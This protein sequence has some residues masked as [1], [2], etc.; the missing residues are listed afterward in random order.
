V[1]PAF[2][3][4]AATEEDRQKI[5]QELKE[6]NDMILSIKG[7]KIETQVV[8]YYA[9]HKAN[10]AEFDKEG[11]LPLH[12]ACEAQANA[13]IIDKLLEIYPEGAKLV[14]KGE[15][16]G[17]LPLHLACM[18]SVTGDTAK[19][20]AARIESVDLMIEAMVNAYPEACTIKQRG[21][22]PLHL[23]SYSNTMHNLILT[24]NANQSWSVTLS[25]AF[26]RI[27]SIFVTFDNDGSRRYYMT[28][29]NN[30]LNWHGKA[31]YRIYGDTKPYNPAYGEGWRFQL[32]AGALLFPD[33]PMS[34]TRE[35]WYQLSKLLGHHASLDGVSIPP[36]VWQASSFV[37]GL[38]MEKAATAPGSGNA[39]FTGMSTRNA[40]DT[41]R[42][43]FDEIGRAHV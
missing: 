18:K 42:F 19:A 6:K 27:K 28:E 3:T 33:I 14:T 38:D 35:A 30:F 16:K 17:D 9:T 20:L 36:G 40:G 21:A 25:R 34:S 2:G 31:D 12:H 37:I 23:S 26:S 39:A 32:Q 15:G 1:R 43:A 22:L 11:Y 10:V 29:S 24:G 41:L 4:M 7:S 5:L 13:T 8:K